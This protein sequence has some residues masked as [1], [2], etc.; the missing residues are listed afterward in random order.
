M[1][2]KKFLI[3]WVYYQ[4]VGHTIEVL[5]YV[6]NFHV[7]NPEIEISLAI[8]AR[9]GVDLAQCVPDVYQVFPVEVSEFEQPASRYPSLEQIPRDWDYYLVDPRHQ[10]PMGQEALDRCEQE[11]RKHIRA[12]AIADDWADWGT[13]PLQGRVTPLTLQLPAAAHQ[14]AQDF[15][16]SPRKTRITLLFGSGS[17]AT[18][19]PPLSFWRKLIGR[20][21]EEFD[22]LEII[23]LGA[24]KAGQSITQGITKAN[25]NDLLSQFPQVRNGFDLGLLNQLAVVERC[26]LH[27][28]PHTG[29]SFAV[30]CVGT[31]WLVISGGDMGENTINGVPLVSIYPDCPYY[32]CGPWLAPQRNPTQPECMERRKNGQPF[33]CLTQ[34]ALEP[35]LPQILVTAHQLVNQELDAVQCARQHYQAMLPRLGI[36][37][38]DPFL[39]GWPAVLSDDFV[40]KKD[41]L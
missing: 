27:I 15:L 2:K 1:H 3:N 14:F 40:F 41:S 6:H 4:P 24:S 32:P 33:L 9:A 35:K 16:A 19:T 20:L 38:G 17:E 22:D 13:F 18:R 7:V 30:Q 12:N 25:I 37:D 36:Q 39:D 21:S 5:R 28:S 23:L 26:Q 10:N 8:N 31:P 11:F 34:E 29:M